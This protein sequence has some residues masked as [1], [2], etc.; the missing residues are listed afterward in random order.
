MLVQRA[1]RFERL[2]QD[3]LVFRRDRFI[4]PALRGRLGEQLGDLPLEIGF[5]V[6]NALR[7]AAERARG[8]QQRIVI[9]LDERLERDVEALAVIEDARDDDR[10][11][12][13][14]PD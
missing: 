13:T 2:Q 6:A 5:D 3:L 7:L 8:M 11:S 14:A 4:E 1:P 9:E 12:A 10:E